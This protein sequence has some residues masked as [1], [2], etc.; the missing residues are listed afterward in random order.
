M[1]SLFFHVGPFFRPN[2]NDHPQLDFLHLQN[3]IS[4]FSVLFL[5]TIELSLN[6]LVLVHWLES[7]RLDII[8]I[9]YVP[10]QGAYFFSFTFIFFL[11]LED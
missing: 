1:F 6:K 11:K 8:D 10:I 9:E 3:G 5:F 7:Y 4:S 2:W